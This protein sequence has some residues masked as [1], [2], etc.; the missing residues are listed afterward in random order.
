MITEK[1][2]V[3]VLGGNIVS[4]KPYAFI[5]EQTDKNTKPVLKLLLEADSCQY[6]SAAVQ[7]S[8]TN[9]DLVILVREDSREKADP[10]LDF[11]LAINKL[12]EVSPAS[13]NTGLDSALV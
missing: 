10:I 6:Y 4:G 8:E 13:P 9:E 11:I 1:G 5:Y 7:P 3:I 12:S 2:R